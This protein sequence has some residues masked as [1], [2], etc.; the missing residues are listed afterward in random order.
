MT[1]Y[2]SKRIM[3]YMNGMSNK[4][5]SIE[6][7]KAIKSSMYKE[8]QDRDLKQIIINTR[9]LKG[10]RELN[11]RVARIA[12]S[13]LASNLIESQHV[14]LYKMC[15]LEEFTDRTGKCAWGFKHVRKSLGFDE[16]TGLE[17]V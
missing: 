9:S 2:V 6:E 10:K 3:E 13:I 14:H 7:V 17:V 15:Q 4:K 16:V 1:G 11:E 8:K 5:F 12:N